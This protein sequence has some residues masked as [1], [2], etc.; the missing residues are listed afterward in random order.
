MNQNIN[1]FRKFYFLLIVFCS[2]IQIIISKTIDDYICLGSLIFINILTLFYCIDQNRFNK[3]PISLSVIFF[4][5]LINSGS[6]LFLKTIELET[7]SSNLL[8][9]THTFTLLF[10]SNLVI[11]GTHQIYK[12]RNEFISNNFFTNLNH[13]LGLFNIDTNFLFFL[14]SFSI[15]SQLFLKPL[16]KQPDLIATYTE[17]TPLAYSILQ[18]F[19]VFY[20]FPFILILSDKL[21]E[22]E[23]KFNKFVLFVFFVAII[24]I[25]VGTNRRDVLFF[26]IL[27][28]FMTLFILYLLDLIK[29]NRNAYIFLIFSIIII[30]I[31]YQKI[32]TFNKVYIYE[33]SIA[34][35]R[36]I[37]QNIKSFYKSLNNL[38]SGNLDLEVYEKYYRYAID[39]SGGFKD[40]YNSLLY[41]R[42]NPIRYADSILNIYQGLNKKNIK[43]INE[44]NMNR[45]ISIVPQPIINIFN[46]NFQKINYIYLTSASFIYQINN[47]KHFS[48]NDVGSF[49]I[50][51]RIFFGIF[52]FLPLIFISYISFIIF[53]SFY[54]KEKKKF[55]PVIIILF[56]AA[57]ASVLDFF[58]SPS[59]NIMAMT[60][61]REIPQT[62]L[63]FVISY[64]T[65]TNLVKHKKN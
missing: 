33:R 40:Y 32:I 47:S 17:G 18:G 52:F 59:F 60:L 2:F 11:I 1:L 12:K 26:G 57:G 16:F 20:L 22:K 38:A 48:R 55:S 6:A 7:I 50:E 15:V 29:L 28:F 51:L 45:I 14:G 25:S 34:D 19:D 61:F 41:E 9:P 21:F 23:Y 31:S 49:L 24:I 27:S 58:A 39:Q 54:N 56:Y 62:V 4:S 30:S 43:E 10:F 36:T 13:K 44:H 46:K 3:F 5:V 53:D 8:S 65:Y 64:Y 37:Q 35:T 63:I 42:I